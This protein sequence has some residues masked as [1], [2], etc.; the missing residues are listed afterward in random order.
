MQNFLENMINKV[1]LQKKKIVLPEGEEIRVI[2]ATSE[3]IKKD[4]ANVI[5]LGDE[6][7]IKKKALEINVNID[8]AVIINP[9]NSEKKDDYAKVLYEKRKHKG[10]TIEK[11]IELI[12]DVT[13]Y[14][15]IMVYVGDA[16]GMVSGSIH[17]TADTLRPALQILKTSKIVSSF[18]IINLKDESFGE[19]GL[20]L[21]SD[22]GLNENPSDEELSE[23]ALSSARSFRTI[24]QKTP[25]IAML[26]YSSLGSAN[27]DIVKKVRN[28]TLLS[29]EKDPDLII[30]GEIQLDAAIIP[31]VSLIKTPSSKIEGK[32]N[33]LIFPDLNS[34]NIGYKLT[35][36]FAKAK[37]YGPITQGL[38][39]PVNDLSRGCNAEDIVGVVTI[40]CLQAQM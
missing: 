8:K 23:I 38:S 20:L 32:A 24:I 7:T 29:R 4:I 19:E 33:V 2:K 36:R 9:K 5:L 15:V 37:A 13:Y 3:I 30:E 31:S 10:M 34:G 14:G 11:S 39:K 35:E 17:S 16:D 26:S 21:F 1:K 18:T 28:A 40:T 27:S 25:R 6:N 22:C 12:Q